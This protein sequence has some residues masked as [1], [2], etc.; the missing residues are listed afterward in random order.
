MLIDGEETTAE[1]ALTRLGAE[2][3]PWHALNGGRCNRLWRIGSY[4]L[5]RYDDTA[6]S[7]MFPND[8][9]AEARALSLL[10]PM[11]LAPNLRAAGSDWVIYDHIPA[12]NWSP[13]ANPAPL[14]RMLHRLHGTPLPKEIFRLLPNGSSALLAHAASFAPQGLPA[15]PADPGLP[16]LPAVPVHSDVVLGNILATG[17]GPLLIDWQ[18]PG[19]GDPSE[20]LAT[21][22]SPAMMW[23]YTGQIAPSGWGDALLRAYPDPEIVGRTRMLLPHYRWRMMAHCAWKAARGAV[24]YAEALRIEIETP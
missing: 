5:K 12:A 13:Q 24:D 16:P 17:Q 6:A 23:L 7:P 2:G 9:R 15:P 11:G 3:L 10:G 21:L 14:A 4:V 20:D 19:L 8:P 22:L 18:C 1:T